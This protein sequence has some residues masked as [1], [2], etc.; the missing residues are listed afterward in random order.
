MF[1]KRD[2]KDKST[3]EPLIQPGERRS[4]MVA[5]GSEPLRVLTEIDMLES[6][7][8]AALQAFR[9]KMADKQNPMSVDEQKKA[10]DKITQLM[11]DRSDKI[12]EEDAKNK[13]KESATAVT[14]TVKK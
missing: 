10:E 13:A 7:L 9:V 12:R 6:Q 1:G 8:Q 2:K 4:G 3:S 14:P 11:R 5:M